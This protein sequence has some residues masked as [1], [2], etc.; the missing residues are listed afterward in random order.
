MIDL[1]KIREEIGITKH[2]FYTQNVAQYKNMHT[3][4]QFYTIKVKNKLREFRK[5][6]VLDFYHSDNSSSIDSNSQKIYPSA[7]WNTLE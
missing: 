7:I 4:M 1:D 3:Y 2:V 5:Q 6:H